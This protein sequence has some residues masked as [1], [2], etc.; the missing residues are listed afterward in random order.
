MDSTGLLGLHIQ[1]TDRKA[2]KKKPELDFMTMDIIE[3]FA[4]DKC[5]TAYDIYTKLNSPSD[6]YYRKM[7]YKNVNKRMHELFSLGLIEEIIPEKKLN[8][9]KAIYYRLTEYGVYRL[10]LNRLTSVVINQFNFRKTQEA[11]INMLTFVY[12]YQNNTIFRL[13]IYPYF[14]RKTLF[15]IWNP[16]LFD[17]YANLNVRRSIRIQIETEYYADSDWR[18]NVLIRN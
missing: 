9:R 7:A 17:L 15:A 12:N 16:L 1:E 10:F 3:Q 13:F 4:W 2:D 8:K 18:S 11:S 14:E 5:R 6:R